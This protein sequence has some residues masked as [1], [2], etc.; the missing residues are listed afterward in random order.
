MLFQISRTVLADHA[1]EMKPVP[2]STGTSSHDKKFATAT[3]MTQQATP[4]QTARQPLVPLENTSAA[5][6]HKMHTQPT[7]AS[8]SSPLLARAALPTNS[9]AEPPID[10]GESTRPIAL[11]PAANKQSHDSRNEPR[12]RADRCRCDAEGRRLRDLPVVDV[13]EALLY[14][15]EFALDSVEP[16]HDEPLVLLPSVATYPARLL[17][18]HAI[19][20]SRLVIVAGPSFAEA[21]RSRPLLGV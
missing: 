2:T 1:S 9:F 3:A 14:P 11:Q 19:Q 6:P 7:H 18:C 4:M 5:A 10:G 8:G 15:V 12:S 21:C 17:C 13:V 16:V 20:C